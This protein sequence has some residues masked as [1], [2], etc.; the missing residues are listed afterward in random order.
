MGADSSARAFFAPGVLRGAAKGLQ[1]V[2]EIRRRPREGVRVEPE[3]GR[4]ARCAGGDQ[5]LERAL[6]AREGRVGPE[7]KRVVDDA[8]QHRGSKRVGLDARR[9]HAARSREGR[10]DPWRD[11]R[12]GRTRGAREAVE[13]AAQ[14]GRVADSAAPDDSSSARSTAFPRSTSAGY[15]RT[16]APETCRRPREAARRSPDRRSPLRSL[17]PESAPVFFHTARVRGPCCYDRV[18]DV[19]AAWAT[20]CPPSSRTADGEGEGGTHGFGVERLLGHVDPP[21]GGKGGDE[22][23]N[24]GPLEGRELG[25]EPLGKLRNGAELAA[26]RLREL[27]EERRD[28]LPV[29]GRDG[30]IE[31]AGLDCGSSTRGTVSVRP[32]SSAEGSNR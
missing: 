13:E 27:V 25:R 15:V 1:G 24:H 10:G 28:L 17:C 5:L 6:R 3:R 16:S 32:S 19:L 11:G 18:G 7:T 30:P 31:L 14:P 8:R 20:T 26:N 23:G 9:R 22:R 4:D 21:R 12:D 29:P 2:V